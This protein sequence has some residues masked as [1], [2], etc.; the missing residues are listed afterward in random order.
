MQDKVH[1]Y[2]LAPMEMAVHETLRT[3][4]TITNVLTAVHI[5]Y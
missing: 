1:V 5:I 3:N 4:T 2:A